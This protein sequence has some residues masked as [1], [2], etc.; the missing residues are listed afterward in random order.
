MTSNL[1]INYCREW[2]DDGKSLTELASVWR[3]RLPGGL[4]VIQG[5]EGGTQEQQDTASAQW[6]AL[7]SP[8]PIRAAI[9]ELK[10]AYL[11]VCGMNSNVIAVNW[12]TSFVF[13]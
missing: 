4:T 3:P 12:L 11:L 13:D 7:L 1:P 6:Q 8:Y 5:L 10:K 2:L 9:E